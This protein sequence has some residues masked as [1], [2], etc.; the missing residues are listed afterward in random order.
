MVGVM[1]QSVPQ[2]SGPSAPFLIAGATQY[3]LVDSTVN[4]RA[5]NVEA[6]GSAREVPR[7]LSPVLDY[8]SAA[9]RLIMIVR[10]GDTGK[11]LSQYPSEALLR[12]Y[13]ETQER[14]ASEAGASSDAG[15]KEKKALPQVPGTDLP[16]AR[17]TA[18]TAVVIESRSSDESKPAAP[19]PAASEGG[20]LSVIV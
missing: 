2:T 14:A 15:A 20:R 17:G 13:R 11:T 8:D 18:E 10:D 7:Y 1:L 19:T 4:S 12:S 16:K 6:A 9:R 3:S 5:E